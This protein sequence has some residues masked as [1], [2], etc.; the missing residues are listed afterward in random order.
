MS[1]IISLICNIHVLKV[2]KQPITKCY[3]AL[4]GETLFRNNNIMKVRCWI[5]SWTDVI[6]SKDIPKPIMTFE[7]NVRY[8]IDYIFIHNIPI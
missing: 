1:L 6:M 7:T 3:K 5:H 8:N 4:P 2:D